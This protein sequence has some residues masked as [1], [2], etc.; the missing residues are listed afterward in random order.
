[1][2]SEI[3]RLKTE[4]K[5]LEDD[6]VALQ[7]RLVSCEETLCGANKRIWYLK[8]SKDCT[9]FKI[10]SGSCQDFSGEEK[11]VLIGSLR[12]FILFVPEIFFPNAP[13]SGSS[14]LDKFLQ[15]VKIDGGQQK[16]KIVRTN[17]QSN[18]GGSCQSIFSLCRHHPTYRAR[19]MCIFTKQRIM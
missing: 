2:K 3:E 11:G 14:G 16:I 1:M 6:I 10:F 5:R 12:G 18:L 9:F 7:G 19:M 8:K 17:G 15:L 13:F 4:K